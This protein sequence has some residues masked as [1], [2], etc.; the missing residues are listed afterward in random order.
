MMRKMRIILIY[1][2]VSKLYLSRL[3]IMFVPLHTPSH[4]MFIVINLESQ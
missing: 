1:Y 2:V 3:Q 4:I